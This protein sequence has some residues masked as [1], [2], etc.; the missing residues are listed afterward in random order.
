MIALLKFALFLSAIFVEI[1]M[2]DSS[3]METAWI[4]QA[5]EVKI[6]QEQAA[7]QEPSRD[8]D[9]ILPV[10]QEI[11]NETAEVFLMFYF[12]GRNRKY[13]SQ[14]EFGSKTALLLQFLH[15]PFPS[16]RKWDRWG[17]PFITWKTRRVSI[18]QLTCSTSSLL[19]RHL[20]SWRISCSWWSMAF[21]SG[22]PAA[23]ATESGVDDKGKYASLER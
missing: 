21:S 18:A 10:L 2:I 12:R 1:M 3:L 20:V 19:C 5:W 6:D 23:C 14:W 15:L 11:K 16:P 13:L 4:E 22:K 8:L 9:L 7:D 17:V